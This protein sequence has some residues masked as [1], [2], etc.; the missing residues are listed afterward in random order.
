MLTLDQLKAM[1]PGIVFAQGEVENSPE[2]VYMT[3]SFPG[4]KL[5]W[6]A[7]RGGIHDWAIY[8]HWADNDYEYVKCHGDKITYEK[9]IKKLVPCD[10]DAFKMYRY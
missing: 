6:V 3:K 9:E 2:G 8:I 5:K 10:H 7:K 4:R 1:P